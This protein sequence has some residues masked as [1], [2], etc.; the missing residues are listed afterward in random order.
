MGT[1]KA[2]TLWYLLHVALLSPESDLSYSIVSER[3]IP[4]QER[5]FYKQL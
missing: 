1:K 2:G 5:L 4:S 3:K